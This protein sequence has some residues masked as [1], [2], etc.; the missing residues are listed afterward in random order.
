[1]KQFTYI[2]KSLFL[3]FSFLVLVCGVVRGA[4]QWDP[5]TTYII[6]NDG[7][8]YYLDSTKTLTAEMKVEGVLEIWSGGT[9]NTSTYTLGLFYYS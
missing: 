6:P 5:S 3:L 4:T 2:K 8:V 7:T 9:L 1:M